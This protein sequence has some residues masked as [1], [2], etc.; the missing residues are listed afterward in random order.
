ML[1]LLLNNLFLLNSFYF[2]ICLKEYMILVKLIFKSM[3][4]KIT[5]K[6]VK[7]YFPILYL[8]NNQCLHPLGLKICLYL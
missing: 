6:S 1:F 7:E 2:Y 4:G 8:V 3:A 5:D